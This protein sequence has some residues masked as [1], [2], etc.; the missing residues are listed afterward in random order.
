MEEIYVSWQ[1]LLWQFEYG[2]L[3]SIPHSNSEKLCVDSVMPLANV[4]AGSL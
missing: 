3:Y 2:L 1:G 4:E